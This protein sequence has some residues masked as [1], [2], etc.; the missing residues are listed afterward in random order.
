[1]KIY[2]MAT[3]ITLTS[4]SSYA[5]E[6]YRHPT[7]G[8]SGTYYV[9]SNEKLN[10]SVSK[11]LTSRVGKN[12]E[13]TDF[14]EVKVNCLSNQYFELAGG[15]EDGLQNK[16]T[17]ILADWSKKSKWAPLVTGS[18]KYDLVQF[19]CNNKSLKLSKLQILI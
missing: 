9:L 10:S 11:V 13:Y 3:L 16:P 15:S 5:N 6:I 1:M 7:S 4:N 12:S 8:D 14:T 18:S 17:K 19:I 2:L